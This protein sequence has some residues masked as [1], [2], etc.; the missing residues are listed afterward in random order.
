ML[1]VRLLES[2]DETCS[3]V[4]FS[5]NVILSFSSFR[6][7]VKLTTF[8]YLFNYLP[9]STSCFRLGQHN[10][11]ILYFTYLI[12]IWFSMAQGRNCRAWLCYTTIIET[13]LLTIVQQKALLKVF[14]WHKA[15][16][17]ER[18]LRISRENYNRCIVI[19]SYKLFNL[20]INSVKR[21]K[22]DIIAE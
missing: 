18:Q 12:L 1:E 3:A 9:S 17:R 20:G 13:S 22:S 4:S 2:N 8:N 6:P 21:S 5:S 10:L 7:V 15:E 14:Q 19:T 16:I 11:P